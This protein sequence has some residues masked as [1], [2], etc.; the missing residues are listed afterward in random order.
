MP[1]KHEHDRVLKFRNIAPNSPEEADLQDHFRLL[2]EAYGRYRALISE[3]DECFQAGAALSAESARIARE[4]RQTSAGSAD[5]PTPP[6]DV[7]RRCA[8]VRAYLDMFEASLSHADRRAR[9]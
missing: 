6:E 7:V 4:F 8:I 5:R 2:E 9:A 3:I 1:L